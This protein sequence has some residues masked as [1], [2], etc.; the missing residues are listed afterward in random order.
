MLDLLGA[1]TATPDPRLPLI[2]DTRKD[3]VK[4]YR[5]VELA[6]G[7]VEGDYDDFSGSTTPPYSWINHTS[8]IENK[9]IPGYVVTPSEIYF[10]K[11]EAIKRGLVSGDAKS[12]FVKGIVESVKLYADINAQSSNSTDN[13]ALSPKVDM[14]AWSNAAIEAYAATKWEDNTDC[15]YKQLWL[16]CGIIN[17]VESWNTIRRTGI[18]KLYYPQ[19]LTSKSKTVP[20]RLVIPRGEL[21]YNK[22][23]REAGIDADVSVGY[24]VVPFWAKKVE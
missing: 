18:P 14:S 19:V 15:I 16:H 22:T 10:Y 20:Q 21:Q 17:V 12:E 11:A 3:G 9:N 23:L 6:A 2:Y 13:I 8:F 1:G 24:L 4:A 5:G 7:K